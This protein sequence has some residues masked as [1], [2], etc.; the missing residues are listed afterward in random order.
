[1]GRKETVHKL[2][3]ALASE[4]FEFIRESEPA[5]PEG[6]VPAP[7]VKNSLGLNFIAVPLAN[8]PRGEKGWLFLILARML[9]DKGLL[10][11]RKEGTRAYYRS[12]R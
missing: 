4:V 3:K 10:E 2:L 8:I 12:K 1:M 5:Y 11:Y 9:E 6:W 7:H